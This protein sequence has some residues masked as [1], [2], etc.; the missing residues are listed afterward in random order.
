MSKLTIGKSYPPN[1]ITFSGR[2]R[3]IRIK[4]VIRV[5]DAADFKI[6]LTN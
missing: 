5:N 1:S 6:K 2:L 3:F 4:C